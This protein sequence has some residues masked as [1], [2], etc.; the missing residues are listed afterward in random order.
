MTMR[1]IS[2]TGQSFSQEEAIDLMLLLS[3]TD[4]NSAKK[5]KGFH[6]SLSKDKLAVDCDEY[7]KDWLNQ[8]KSFC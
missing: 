7:W 3:S 5:W 1:L 8:I 2:N 4:A 6:N